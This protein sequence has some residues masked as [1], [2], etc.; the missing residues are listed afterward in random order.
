M[1]LLYLGSVFNTTSE[2]NTN[3]FPSL[4]LFLILLST[5]EFNKDANLLLLLDNHNGNSNPF[6]NLFKSK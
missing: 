3:D 1:L 6:F 5:I 2:S 4:F